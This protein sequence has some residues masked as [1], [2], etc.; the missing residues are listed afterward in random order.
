MSFAL[1]ESALLDGSKDVTRRAGW[2]TLKPGDRL[3]AVRKG[4]GLK[5]GEHP[6]VLRQIEVVSVRRERLGLMIEDDAYGVDEVRREG[7]GANSP[8]WFVEMFARTHKGVTADTL[9]TRIEFRACAPTR[10]A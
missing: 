7:F 3:R 6:V 9:V 1:T 5:K 8:R 2:L 10:R 4:M